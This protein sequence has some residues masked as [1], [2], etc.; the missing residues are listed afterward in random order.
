M[1][2]RLIRD[3]KQR[4]PRYNPKVARN[5][6]ERGK[7]YPIPKYLPAP[8][9]TEIT[10]PNAWKLVVNGDA[11]PACTESTERCLEYFLARGKTSEEGMAEAK[12]LRDRLDKSI[13]PKHFEAYDEGR[14]D[15]YDEKGRPVLNGELVE[16]EEDQPQDQFVIIVNEPSEAK[17][18]PAK[19]KPKPEVL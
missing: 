2:V 5:F 12:R 17:E 7:R 18:R 1:K 11:E 19:R 13:H 3:L 8:A 4:N 9:G 10:N 15:G 14:L 16:L 6:Q